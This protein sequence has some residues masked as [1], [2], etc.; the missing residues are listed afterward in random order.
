LLSSWRT[1]KIQSQSVTHWAPSVHRLTHSCAKN[2]LLSI[3]TSTFT[4]RP[5]L[6]VPLNAQDIPKSLDHWS[7]DLDS[8]EMIV[9]K[10]KALYRCMA[11]V[12]IKMWFEIGLRART[13][14]E[15]NI[16]INL[17]FG[18]PSI[19]LLKLLGTSLC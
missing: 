14:A 12:E 16:Q 8:W 18:K 9:S 6:T 5:F 3:D 1:A 17:F 11:R 13:T 7:L 19:S 15:H 2:I 10:R 4:P